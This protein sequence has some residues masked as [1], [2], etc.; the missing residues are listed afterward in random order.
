MKSCPITPVG[1]DEVGPAAEGGIFS[2]PRSG[3]THMYAR[4]AGRADE[5]G[6]YGG[7]GVRAGP[8]KSAPT[9]GRGCGRADE[10]G[11][12]GGPSNLHYISSGVT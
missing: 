11:P 9:E 12:Y 8:T 3:L 2:R 5:V 1:A 6:P 7:Q 10:V 4:F